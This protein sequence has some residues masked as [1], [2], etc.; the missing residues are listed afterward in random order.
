MCV[1]TG[2]IAQK[3]HYALASWLST[4][5][6][7]RVHRDVVA[8]DDLLQAFQDLHIQNNSLILTISAEKKRQLL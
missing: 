2:G 8:V 1:W 4:P 7:V 6:N 3:S 5:I